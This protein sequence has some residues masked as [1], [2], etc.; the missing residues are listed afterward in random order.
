MSIYFRN[1]VYLVNN[2]ISVKFSHTSLK[3]NIL[4]C[5]H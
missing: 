1:I 5:N 3:E 2:K 4:P